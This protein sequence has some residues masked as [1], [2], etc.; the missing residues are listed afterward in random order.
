MVSTVSFYSI[1]CYATVLQTK[2]SYYS[3]VSRSNLC[4]MVTGTNSAGPERIAACFK[5]IKS[6][7]R[8]R[9]LVP[10]LGCLTHAKLNA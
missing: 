5:G 2:M 8:N 6:K 9:L 7:Q 10:K 3:F 4:K 1:L